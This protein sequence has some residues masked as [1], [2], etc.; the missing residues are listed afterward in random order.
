M[1]EKIFNKL[2]PTKEQQEHKEMVFELAYKVGGLSFL[3]L[4]FAIPVLLRYF[5]II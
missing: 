1:F 5:G 2:E 3:L 4:S